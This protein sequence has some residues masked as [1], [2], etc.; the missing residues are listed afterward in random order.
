MNSYLAALILLL[1]AIYGV[2]ARKTY[3][4][5]PARELKRRAEARDPLAVRLYPA[6][7]YGGSLRGLL[8]AWIGL[9]TAGA[10][11][12]LAQVA[13]AWISFIAIVALLWAVHSWLPAS[14]VT[15]LGMNLT[16]LVTPLVVWLLHY[17]HRPLSRATTVVQKSYTAEAHTGLFERQDMLAL[18]EQQQRQTDNRVRDEELEIAKRALNFGEL[19]V[20][21]VMTPRKKVKTA[22]ASDTVGPV[23]IDELHKNGQG[24]L[25]VRESAKGDFVGLL[26]F[27]RL[28]LKSSG[29]VKNLMDKE[30]YYLNENDP[31]DQAL[32]AFFTTNCPLFVVVDSSADYVGIISIDALLRQL[33]GHVPGEDFE[34]Y[35]EKAAVALRHPR[36]A[37]KDKK[38]AE[39]PEPHPQAEAAAA[40]KPAEKSPASADTPVKTDD[41]VVK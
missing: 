25:L 11:V 26:A 8:W 29:Q 3:Y 37:G 16:S 39:S 1:I 31:L 35:H 24:Y 23:L 33:L 2:V 14:R 7:A 28:S 38:A 21:D 40:E 10:F 15:K 19:R 32:H 4:Y 27:K 6:V 17:L 41:E 13:P 22:L 36:P 5:L 20:R 9:P 34:Q 12:L 30:V 18:I